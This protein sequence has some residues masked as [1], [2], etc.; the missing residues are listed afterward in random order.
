MSQREA[1][2][3]D[4]ATKVALDRFEALAAEARDTLIEETRRSLETLK[5]TAEESRATAADAAEDSRMRAERLGETLF[6]AA[7]KADQAADAR[8]AE[9]RR[10]VHET[11]GLVGEAGDLALDRLEATLERM[12]A[13][14]ARADAAVVEIDQKAAGLPEQARERIDAVRLAVEDG[15]AALSAASE[16]AARDTEALDAGFQERVRRNY[17]MLTEAVR[18]M[19]VVS[20]D[21]P[22]PR[23]REPIAAPPTPPETPPPARRARSEE[24]RGFG[25][26]GRLKLT[27]ADGSRPP[28]DEQLGWNDL[29]QADDAG[30]PPMDLTAPVM[31]PP[32]VEALAERI[33]VAIRR[34]GVDPN[35]LLPRARI[36]EAAQA[37]SSNDPG[38]ARLIVRR[39]APAAVRSVSRR[40]LSDADMKA[41]AERYVRA[42]ARELQAFG[43]E[44]TG[45]LARLATDGG[46]AF[47]LLDAAVGDLA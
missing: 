4:A 6:D 15:L 8:I 43:P 26:R 5:A 30:E 16:K 31:P 38:G 32:D 20:G 24:G 41:D 35:A 22:P 44:S 36:E 7:Q 27:P 34:M 28:S 14:L 46:R 1:D 2:G 33:V 25:L 18:L 37:W 13:V 23:R 12:N 39:V 42:F 47:L 3:F 9:A 17:D 45:V 11:T 10:I 21:S 19:G 40:V 29:V